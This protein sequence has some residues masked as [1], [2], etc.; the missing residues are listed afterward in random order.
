MCKTSMWSKIVGAD[1]HEEGPRCFVHLVI[2]LYVHGSCQ[3]VV[4]CGWHQYGCGSKS[5]F[6]SLWTFAFEALHSFLCFD[7]C[8]A[9]Q[10]DVFHVSCQ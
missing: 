1:A 6:V 9:A 7:W 10:I 3:E 4:W 2:A 5:S 8:G